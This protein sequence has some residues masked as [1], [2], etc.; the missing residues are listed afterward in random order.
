MCRAR[1]LA[2]LLLLSPTAFAQERAVEIEASYTVTVDRLS[3]NPQAGIITRQ[4]LRLHL[5]GRNRV[6]EV[7]QRRSGFASR[8]QAATE[9]LG[10]GRWRIL[11]GNR[12]VE[13][14]D[15]PQ[16][17]T[18]VTITASGNACRI[19]VDYRLKPGFS[20]YV[21]RRVTNRRF[22]FFD[23]PRVIASECHI[24]QAL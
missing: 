19:D 8:E 23:K 7:W 20:E 11:P 5:S 14:I 2:C 18:V 17:V 9:R 15:A 16:N 1:L 4:N 12:I 22:A 3:P 10:R 24:T 21:F 6:E 13:V